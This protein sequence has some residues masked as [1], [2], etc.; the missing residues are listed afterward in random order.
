MKKNKIYIIIG[1]LLV[2]I[3]AIFALFYPKD[4]KGKESKVNKEK[5]VKIIPKKK[6]N[7]T[8][9]HNEKDYNSL[10][11]AKSYLDD[12][13]QQSNDKEAVKTSINEMISYLESEEDFMSVYP[14]YEAHLN[15]TSVY[16]IQTL[17]Q[18]IK[19]D[20]KLEDNIEVYDTGEKNIKQVI[21]SFSKEAVS[22]ISYLFNYNT[23]STQFELVNLYGNLDDF[24]AK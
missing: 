24:A 16:D 1:I 7:Y 8:K 22:T 11:E 15:D 5:I 4:S 13:A 10:E 19:S 6:S 14:S 23:E 21:I 3:I 20:Y 12:S 17:A 9:K 2:V 18:I